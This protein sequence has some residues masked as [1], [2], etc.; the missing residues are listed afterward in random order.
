MLRHI[1]FLIVALSPFPAAADGL[2]RIA[3]SFTVE[4]VDTEPC[5]ETDYEIS[6]VYMPD[7][8]GKRFRAANPTETPPD[9][10]TVEVSDVAGDFKA[11]PITAGGFG[12]P[13]TGFVAFNAQATQR[14]LTIAE[15]K[16]RYSIHMRAQGMSLYY[17]GT[18]VEVTN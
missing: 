16:G 12:H 10:F 1:L 14:L 2:Q 4:C 7:P 3:C 13:M 6:A 8:S 15:G 18:C 11:A 9:A 5:G 17:E